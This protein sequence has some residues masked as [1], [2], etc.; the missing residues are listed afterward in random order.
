MG[1]I[2]DGL[3]NGDF[4]EIT[5]EYLGKGFGYPRTRVKG[6]YNTIKQEE[7]EAEKQIRVIRKEIAI[8][9]KSGIPLEEARRQ[10]NLK[11]GYGWRD[12]GLV[13]KI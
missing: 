11:H 2:A 4:D 12:R 6:Q 9:V 10:A 5:G 1:D 7:T 3:I 8:A 13:K